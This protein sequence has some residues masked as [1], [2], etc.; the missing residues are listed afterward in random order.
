M[1]S[2][3]PSQCTVCGQPTSNKC[4]RCKTQ[5]YCGTECQKTDWEN[6][7]LP[8]KRIELDQPENVEKLEK[9]MKRAAI[10]IQEAFL[11]FREK[12]WDIPIVKIENSAKGVVIH[13]AAHVGDL[14]YFVDLPHGIVNNQPTQVAVIC[15]LACNQPWAWMHDIIR[16][17]FQSKLVYSIATCA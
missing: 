1:A 17:T 9:V 13:E 6:H 3:I 11:D 15:A 2:E 12:T 5:V 4:G 10:T 7:K 14:K 16:K 8:C